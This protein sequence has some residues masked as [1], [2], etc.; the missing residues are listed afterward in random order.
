[1]TQGY[2]DFYIGNSEKVSL[3]SNGTHSFFI[4]DPTSAVIYLYA[5]NNFDG[6]IDNVSVKKV[7]N[8]T[9]RL[10]YSGTEPALLLEPQRTNNVTYSEDFSQSYWFNSG[11]NVTP[12]QAIAPD[13]TTTADLTELSSNNNRLGKDISSS[14]GTYTFSFYVKA[15]EGESGVWVSRL[16][17][18]SV[19]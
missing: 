9:P 19:V 5:F 12:N 13:G 17:R 14:A 18:K 1:M 10:D 6:E 8:D 11:V 16:D 7:S 15:K 4:S 3:D 2:V